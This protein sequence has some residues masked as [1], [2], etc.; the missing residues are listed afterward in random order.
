MNINN[1]NSQNNLGGTE[2]KEIGHIKMPTIPSINI[3]LIQNRKTYNYKTNSSNSQ[4]YQNGIGNINYLEMIKKTNKAILKKYSDLCDKKIEYLKYMNDRKNK[5]NQDKTNSSNE[6]KN[7]NNI[8]EIDKLKYHPTRES[9]FDNSENRNN[10]HT[11]FDSLNSKKLQQK[12]A[13]IFESIIKKN[14]P[15]Y[16][17]HRN[18]N[19]CFKLRKNNEKTI[20]NSL[21]T[22][23]SKEELFLNY[24]KFKNT[25]LIIN[26]SISIITNT[27]IRNT[28]NSFLKLLIFLN[29][30][31]ILKLF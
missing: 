28:N 1:S 23:Y 10:I 5:S 8:N 22:I 18:K 21:E 25:F 13:K 2:E 16:H 11:D 30:N 24:K 3:S 4:K 17:K 7:I 29:N 19:M 12:N 14:M 15:I 27:K 6:D 26:D 31:E 20:K 9:T